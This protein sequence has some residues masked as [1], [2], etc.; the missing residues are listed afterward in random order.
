MLRI[1]FSNEPIVFRAAVLAVGISSDWL[2]PADQVRALS[3]ALS[4][5]GGDARYAE[6]QSPN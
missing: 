5:V 6:I 4:A 2:Y 3:D 1:A